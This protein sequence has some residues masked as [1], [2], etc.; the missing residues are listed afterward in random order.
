MDTNAVKALIESRGYHVSLH[1]LGEYVELHAFK[2]DEL[3]DLGD[4]TAVPTELR[5]VR[6]EGNAIRD[7]AVAMLELARICGIDLS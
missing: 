5:I 3:Q 6:V 4:N 2:L 1:Q 7:M